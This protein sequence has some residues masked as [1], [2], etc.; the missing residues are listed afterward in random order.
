[1]SEMPGVLLRDYENSDTGMKLLFETTCV[2]NEYWDGT[3]Y[4]LV[5]IDDESL[6]LAIAIRNAGMKFLKTLPKIS[7]DEFGTG[8]VDW[9]S[10]IHFELF[11]DDA[12]GTVQKLLNEGGNF[13]HAFPEKC[14][15]VPDDWEIPDACD[16]A[17]TDVH[18]LRINSSFGDLWLRAQS[19]CSPDYVEIALPMGLLFPND[20]RYKD[21]KSVRMVKIK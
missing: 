3:T 11:D 18:E 10:P 20:P 12:E 2:S 19:D 5:N 16:Q 9:E 8:A 4:T 1:M 15:I 7:E 17:A 14:V 6:R 21:E 13:A